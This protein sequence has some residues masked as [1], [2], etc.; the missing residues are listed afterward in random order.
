MN[1]CR[2]FVL[3]EP[4]EGTKYIFLLRKCI[5]WSTARDVLERTSMAK[6]YLVDD[7]E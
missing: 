7:V 4:S 3:V 2:Y 6:I 5:P 1:L